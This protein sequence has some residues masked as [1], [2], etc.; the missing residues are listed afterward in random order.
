MTRDNTPS[1]FAALLV[2]L[3]A[4]VL[5]RT[6][7][8]YWTR[9]GLAM[10]PVTAALLALF[11]WVF[12]RCWR[13][14]PNPLFR[15]LFALLLVYSSSLELL[16][17][18]QLSARLYPDTVT[19]AGVCF[20]V[21]LPVIYLRRVSAIGQ[22]AN[23]LLCAVVIAGA[24]LLLSLAPRLHLT[25]L[26]MPVLSE[27]VLSEAVS[28]QLILYPEYLLPALWPE[29][30]KRGRHTLARLAVFAIGFDVAM[31]GV[32]E[33]FFGAAMPGRADPVHAAARC[34]A[35]SVFNRLEWVQLL[36]WTMAVS[37]KLAL[38]LYALHRLC[39]RPGPTENTAVG[40]E[41]F[42]LYFALLLALCLVLHTANL[43]ALLAARNTAVWFF[44]ALVVM[45]GGFACLVSNRNSC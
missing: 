17:L 7:T 3:L 33:L 13:A 43:A 6:Q 22:T 4:N 18:W 30:D 37:L 29:Q 14:W 26:Q 1:L 5:L 35:L 36:L 45:G 44:A 12:A 20:T 23:V 39:K 8:G 25:N 2:S 10:A 9:A 40:L 24:A 21:L 27:N 31:H 34:G 16:R 15:G 11:G 28:A 32:L 38:Y 41:R 42:P 19:L